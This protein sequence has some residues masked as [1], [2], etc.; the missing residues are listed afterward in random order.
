MKLKSE[1]IGS[2]TLL[3]KSDINNTEEK[4]IEIFIH[5]TCKR[6]TQE[7]VYQGFRKDEF[8]PEDLLNYCLRNAGLLVVVSVC[9][10]VCPGVMV[11][12]SQ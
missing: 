3:R 1:T 7:Y 11:F 12:F 9:V 10:C 2:F 4:E 5:E 8:N 6:S